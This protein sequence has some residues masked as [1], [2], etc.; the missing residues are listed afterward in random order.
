MAN[1][2][3]QGGTSTDAELNANWVGGTKPGAGDVAIFDSTAQRTCQLT[4]GVGWQGISAD[5]TF[6][7]DFDQNGQTITLSTGGMTWDGDGTITVTLDAAITIT[8]DCN[9]QFNGGVSTYTT[10]S[11]DLDL[12][13]TGTF[14]HGK[15]L[16]LHKLTCAAN[17]KTTTF[18]ASAGY[19][20]LTQWTLGA[21]TF[22]HSATTDIYADAKALNDFT[23]DANHTIDGS[24]T[25]NV[26]LRT[27]T[28][29]TFNVPKI[30]AGGWT[31]GSIGITSGS[32]L[33]GVVADMQGTIT[34]SATGDVQLYKYSDGDTTINTNNHNIT[35]RNISGGNSNANGTTT[36]NFGSSTIDVGGYALWSTATGPSVANLQTSTW[37]I[38]GSNLTWGTAFT[39]NEGTSSITLDGSGAQLI[40]SN[41]EPMYNVTVANTGGTTSIADALSCNTLVLS[42][43]DFDQNGQTM[44][45]SGDWTISTGAGD[46]I[47]LDAA[48]SMT[49][50]NATWTVGQNV[51]EA[52]TG[53]TVTW[54]GT[55][56]TA[57]IS[58]IFVIDSLVLGAS[59]GLTFSNTGAPAN[60]HLAMYS[61]GTALTMGNNSTLTCNQLIDLHAL[62]TS[63]LWSIGTGCTWNGSAACN[64]TAGADDITIS[65]PSLT[66][67]GTGGLTFTGGGDAVRTGWVFQLT[68]ALSVA[69]ANI[70]SYCGNN[71]TGTFDLNDQDVTCQN[72]YNGVSGA[73][74]IFTTRL[75]NGTLTVDNYYGHVYDTGTHNLFLEG[76]TINLSSAVGPAFGWWYGSNHTVNAGTATI[77]FLGTAAQGITTNGKTMPSVVINKTGGTLTLQDAYVGGAFTLT[78]G[79][80]DM[81]GQTM[82]IT[83]WTH[84]TSDAT[85]LDAAITNSGNGTYNVVDIYNRLILTAGTTHTF[86]A[87]WTL[88]NYTVGD[89]D[90]IIIVSSVGGTQR[91]FTNPVGM[92]VANINVT[93]S[94]ALN[95]IDNTS[96]GVNGGNN[97]NWLFPAGGVSISTSK[98]AIGIGI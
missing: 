87:N 8:G 16:T 22:T 85:T 84:N 94:V 45:M 34:M 68:G 58:N 96:G 51:V 2:T 55:G 76:V 5:N 49:G 41:G 44:S 6:D 32:S 48:I 56:G 69:S 1:I 75:G 59:A 28:N 19:L 93:D 39:V 24:G 89:L 40:T 7:Q 18:D 4:A 88:S 71:Y 46:T 15:A 43:G 26:Y 65:C 11:C 67:T 33:N 29:I 57:A 20:V 3:W 98:I 60:P 10:S 61:S 12:Q 53:A 86:G 81:N 90:G 21:G 66:Y 47:T 92:V 97:V 82:S 74:G 91:N 77:N 35:C 23:F 54:T 9:A 17:T 50:N 62:T 78:D 80:F 25:G 83:G 14:G 95:E 79:A 72:F 31:N 38:A 52:A 37:T 63:N 36:I 73:A 30:N 27:S 70:T 13:G 42:N 64:L